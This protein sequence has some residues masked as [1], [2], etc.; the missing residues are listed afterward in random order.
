MAENTAG[1]K[2]AL[3]NVQFKTTPQ[4]K[5]QLKIM[6]VDLGFTQQD[7]LAAILHMIIAEHRRDAKMIRE[8]LATAG[9]A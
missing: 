7:V 5:A 3:A 4:D 2:P 8:L 1:G 6:C 9:L